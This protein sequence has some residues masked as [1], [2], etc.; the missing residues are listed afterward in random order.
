MGTSPAG[1]HESVRFGK[2]FEIDLR[3]FELRHL[4]RA[5]KLERIPLQVLV[6]LI[7]QKGQLV[8]REEIA[9]KIWGKDVFLD[10]DNSINSAIRKI[11]QALKDDPQ[12]PRYV[13]TLPGR[14]YRFIAPVFDGVPVSPQA[15]GTPAQHPE[16]VSLR[17]HLVSEQSYKTDQPVVAL[18]APHWQKLRFW[19]ALFSC[20]AIL[21]VAWIGW[22]HFYGAGAGSPI[23]SIAV[24]PL[25]NLS[26]DPAQDFFADGMTEELITE[27]SRIQSLRV[28]SHTSVMEYKG[29]KKHLPQIAHELGVDGVLE[30]S[31]IREND[32]VRVTVQLLDGPNDRHIWS[33]S[34][35]RPLH[36]VLNLQREV[37]EAVT[38][39]IRIQ[40]TPE[41]QARVGSARSVNPEAFDAYLRGRYNLSTQF[42]MG[43]P[44]LQAKSYFEESIRKDPGFAEAYSGLA[45]A[46]LYLAIFRHVPLKTAF[47]SAHEALRR[48]QQLDDSIGEVHDTLGVI[49]WRYDRNLDE[50]EREFNRAIATAPSY[51]CAHEDRAE[52]LAFLGR[53]AEAMAEMARINQIDLG[54]S[55]A[56]TEAGVYYQLRDYSALVDAAKRGVASNPNEWVEH[57]DLGIGY[58]GTGKLSEAISEYQKAVELSN[59]DQDANASLAHAYAVTGKRAEAEQILRDLQNRSKDNEVSPYIVATVYAGLGEKEKAM[60]FLEKA[61]N[62]R[63]LDIS[64]HL[65][66]D[67]RIDNLRSDPR[68]QTLSQKM[69][70]AR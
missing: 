18:A 25:Q 46:Y 38:R 16:Q 26:G 39:Q 10:T 65:K 45:D 11:R 50:A 34:Y 14:G 62:E 9:G 49:S 41:Q 31:V 51:P 1:T 35:E 48:A 12:Q 3:A 13:E 47:Q 8:T 60:Q 30:G 69:G 6:I 61:S 7:E 29:T 22:H 54:P 59:G 28:I 15:A 17:P 5:L 52:F 57:Q 2:D 53:R 37:A 66:A 68:F 24:L 20:C 32:E 58:E 70:I 64:W 27:L 33:E 36:G 23:R 55:A 44:L 43:Q 56:M 4:G 67:P 21:L 42:T 40:L 19:I 63:S